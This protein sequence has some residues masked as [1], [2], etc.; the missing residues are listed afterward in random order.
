VGTRNPVDGN[1]LA[2]LVQRTGQ[3]ARI[4]SYDN[5][6]GSIAARVRAGRRARDGR[7]ADHR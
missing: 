5:V 4:D 7:G 6:A 2:S 1:T 3:P